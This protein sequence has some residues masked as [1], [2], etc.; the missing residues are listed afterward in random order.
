MFPKVGRGCS[1]QYS[2]MALS[3]YKQTKSNLTTIPTLTIIPLSGIMSQYVPLLRSVS[4]I[5]SCNESIW[6][7]LA[8]S[9]YGPLLKWVSMVLSCDQS[10]Y[11]SLAMSRCD[12]LLQWVNMGPLLRWVN[13]IFSCNMVSTY[14]YV[15]CAVPGLE[16][17]LP[18]GASRFV[19]GTLWLGSFLVW[20][21]WGDAG[22]ELQR[23]RRNTPLLYSTPV[24]PPKSVQRSSSLTLQ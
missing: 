24:K 11:S 6:S 16:E 4:M 19:W 21:W 18:V 2:T 1:S 22:R 7:A 13:I 9:Q 14:M 20:R 3:C 23:G 8:M 17:G 15:L 10:V 5:L 12:P